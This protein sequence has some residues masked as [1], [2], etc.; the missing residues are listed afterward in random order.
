MGLK[1]RKLLCSSISR[2]LYQDVEHEGCNGSDTCNWTCCLCTRAST[3]GRESRL[4]R[5]KPRTS[6]PKFDA[7]D[8]IGGGFKKTK[9]LCQPG[10]KCNRCWCNDQDSRE[11]TW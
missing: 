1:L 2:L 8:C 5:R 6:N 10:V 4:F 3:M 9:V 11:I 7:R